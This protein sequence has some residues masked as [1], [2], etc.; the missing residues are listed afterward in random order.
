MY[1]TYKLSITRTNLLY[2]ISRGDLR[3]PCVKFYK[4]PPECTQCKL[5]TRQRNVVLSAKGGGGWNSE[6]RDG[7][8]NFGTHPTTTS[9]LEKRRE[10]K[11]RKVTENT[12]TP[13]DRPGHHLV[14]VVVLLRCLS[15][16]GIR[17]T[18]AHGAVSK[19]QRVKQLSVRVTTISGK[20]WRRKWR[21]TLS[22]GVVVQQVCGYMVSRL[23]V[24]KVAR[25]LDFW[26]H[27]CESRNYLHLREGAGSY[28]TNRLL[29]V[30]CG[31]SGISVTIFSLSSH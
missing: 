1:L 7:F 23:R 10:G 29:I 17:A 11:N 6:I 30:L 31:T 24:E 2:I 20:N 4:K 8:P 9:L 21:K 5:Q 28:I 19:N 26:F 16:R 22:G 13:N 14:P 3:R 27:F 18:G 15:R 12:G 25:G